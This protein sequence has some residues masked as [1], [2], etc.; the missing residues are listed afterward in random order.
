[1]QIAP[2]DWSRFWNALGFGLSNRRRRRA[3]ESRRRSTTRRHG[4]DRLEQRVVLNADPVAINDEF[5]VDY[6]GSIAISQASLTANDQDEDSDPLSVVGGDWTTAQG[7]AVSWSAYGEFIYTPPTGFVG[8]DTF[9]YLVGDGLGGMSQAAV[10][11]HVAPAPNTPPTGES[12]TYDLSEDGSLFIEP[13]YGLLVTAH[14]AEGQTLHVELVAGPEHGS[15]SLSADGSFT[16]TPNADWSGTDS[17]TYHLSD[18]VDVSTDYVV[19]LNVLAVNDAPSFAAGAG[20]VAYINQGLVVIPN[21][22]AGFDVGP[23]DESGQQFHIEIEVEYGGEQLFHLLPTVDAEGTLSFAPSGVAGNTMFTVRVVDDGGTERGGVNASASSSIAVTI[24]DPLAGEPAPGA[25]TSTTWPTAYFTAPVID[26]AEDAAGGKAVFT[27]K[28]SKGFD[29]PVVVGWFAEGYSAHAGIDFAAASGYLTFAPGQTTAQIEIDVVNDSRER[30]N[31]RSFGVRLFAVSNV[32]VESGGAAAARIVEDDATLSWFEDVNGTEQAPDTAGNLPEMVFTLQLSRALSHDVT[33]NVSDI[34]LSAGSDD[35]ALLDDGAITF[36][37]GETSKEIRVRILNDD[38]RTADPNDVNLRRGEST[39]WFRLDVTTSDPHL[40]VARP[41]A[42]GSIVDDDWQQYIEVEPETT[43]GYWHLLFDPAQYPE[44]TVI[45]DAPLGPGFVVPADWEGYYEWIETTTPAVW[46][47]ASTS[48]YDDPNAIISLERLDDEVVWEKDGAQMR[49]RIHVIGN[50]SGSPITVHYATAGLTADDGED[51]ENGTGSVT[52]SGEYGSA[53]VAVD[54]LRDDATEPYEV[55]VFYIDAIAGAVMTGW[56]SQLVAVRSAEVTSIEFREIMDSAAGG[57]LEEMSGGAGYRFFPDADVQIDGAGNAVAGT[58]QGRNL[59]RVR[60]YV[61]GLGEGDRVYFKVFDVDDPSRADA[62]DAGEPSG[63]DNFGRLAIQ[64][65]PQGN[66]VGSSLYTP[67]NPNE[68][69]IRYLI[70]GLDADG[71][72]NAWYGDGAEKIVSGIV[73]REA[74]TGRLYAEAELLTTFQPGDNFRVVA[75]P[76]FEAGNDWD[77]DD[78][79][80]RTEIVE[81]FDS[82]ALS[83]FADSK[84]GAQIE[85]FGALA[86]PLLTVWRRLHMEI[87]RMT[88][89]PGDEELGDRVGATVAQSVA[90]TGGSITVYV[91]PASWDNITENCFEGGLLRIGNKNYDIATSG[92]R[93]FNGQQV[94]AVGLRFRADLS[95]SFTQNDGVTL[96]ED[97]FVRPEGNGDNEPQLRIAPNKAGLIDVVKRYMQPGRNVDMNRF[98]EAFIQ[99]EYDKLAAFSGWLPRVNHVESDMVNDPQVQLGG[100]MAYRGSANL[101]STTFWTSYLA[102]AYQFAAGQDFDSDLAMPGAMDSDEP[103]SQTGVTGSGDFYAVSF[104]FVESVWDHWSA[105][106]QLSPTNAEFHQSQNPE[107]ALSRAAIHEIGLQFGLESSVDPVTGEEIVDGIM[108]DGTHKVSAAKF[109]F[110]A[111]NLREIRSQLRTG[112]PNPVV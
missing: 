22:A 91:V 54:I 100:E 79:Q 71:H 9:N 89:L 50:Y 66:I 92:I 33:V 27:V 40:K 105:H 16:Y 47:W 34:G 35:Y 109:Y 28:L 49:F 8:D 18:G 58:D 107:N 98:A 44:G 85:E 41:Y 46:E 38:H 13:Q 74:V 106:R 6:G 80:T 10:T 95:V 51:Y 19:T 45:D 53:D 81:A 36:A 42:I 4:Y 43:T 87:D 59:V 21:W 57:D 62:E 70:R 56:Q 67:G 94:L 55:F 52:I 20:L 37:A 7:V 84:P 93:D 5:E 78:G 86:S 24:I 29:E 31:E 73:R 17:F 60:A 111:D 65:D 104:V 63:D 82:Q 26:V 61:E 110:T 68:G 3:A 1:M 99:P 90:G 112:Q 102:I 72:G 12:R 14:D 96:F 2:R 75:L 25:D 23:E 32:M 76:Q 101:N 77:P 11:I 30:L 69:N 15:F 83:G 39:E 97:D 64:R 88:D 108:T 48:G 103:N